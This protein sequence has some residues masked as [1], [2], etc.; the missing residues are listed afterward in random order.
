MSNF[1]DAA[2]AEL[3]DECV[4]QFEFEEDRAHSESQLTGDIEVAKPGLA[5]ASKR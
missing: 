2:S 4:L 5:S 3:S 1:R